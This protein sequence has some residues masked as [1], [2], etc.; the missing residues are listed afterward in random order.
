MK[1]RWG[2]RKLGDRW[3]WRAFCLR[4]GTRAQTKRGPRG[5]H[6][7]EYVTPDKKVHPERPVPTCPGKKGLA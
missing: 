4:C 5:G 7:V 2:P 3:G 6:L 1:H